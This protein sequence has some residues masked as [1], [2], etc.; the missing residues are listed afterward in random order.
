MTFPTP[1]LQEVEEFRR[2]FA[3][4]FLIELNS[5]EALEIASKYIQMYLIIRHEP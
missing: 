5:E 2:L 1:T 4:R 3:E